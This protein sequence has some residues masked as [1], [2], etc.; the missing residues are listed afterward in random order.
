MDPYN[1]RSNPLNLPVDTRID[2][3]NFP[4][5]SVQTPQTDY[6][7]LLKQYIEEII[8]NFIQSG[9]PYSFSVHPKV[10][11]FRLVKQYKY[12]VSKNIGEIPIEQLMS[13]YVEAVQS[14][15]SFISKYGNLYLTAFISNAKFED[16]Y[17]EEVMERYNTLIE[18]GVDFIEEYVESSVFK[19][20]DFLNQLI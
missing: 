4:F 3:L 6:S 14:T 18:I 12:F 17:P 16:F 20:I 5:G 2:P 13:F 7:T 8:Y 15:F 9:I 10:L 1:F 11:V 19:K